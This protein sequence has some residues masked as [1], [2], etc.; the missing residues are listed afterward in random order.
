MFE[1]TRKIIRRKK[2]H[3]KQKVENPCFRELKYFKTRKT[4]SCNVFSV[5]ASEKFPAPRSL[6]Y[7]NEFKITISR[8][9][10]ASQR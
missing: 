4:D 8:F 2:V 7:S 10:T 5:R 6:K 1:V 3:S 9:L